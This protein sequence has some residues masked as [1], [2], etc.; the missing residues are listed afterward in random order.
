MKRTR[1]LSFAKVIEKL[2][3]MP[4]Y[5][6]VPIAY[7]TLAILNIPI[8][9]ILDLLKV[10][11]SIVNSQ[12][13][14]TNNWLKYLFVVLA[15]P[16]FETFI[17]QSIPYYLFGLFSFFKRHNWITIILASLLFGLSHD[18]SIQFI[19]RA[20]LFGFFLISTYYIRVRKNDSF[21]ATYL[22]HALYNL[23]AVTVS[24]FI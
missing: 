2:E 16:F 23:V 11:D 12:N 10:P 7:I 17:F 21:L 1:N 14:P 15:G 20:T 22:L 13:L 6:Y 3:I 5:W 9:F 24:L 18:F 8:D 4:I 19:I